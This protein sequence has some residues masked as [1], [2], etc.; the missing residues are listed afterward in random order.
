MASKASPVTLLRLVPW[1]VPARLLQGLP[2]PYETLT[3]AYGSRQQ[4]PPTQEG[5]VSALGT[6]LPY[7]M[8]HRS[9]L[10]GAVQDVKRR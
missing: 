2:C 3:A 9:R 4:A 7:L 8:S 5:R 10:L 6:L 1:V